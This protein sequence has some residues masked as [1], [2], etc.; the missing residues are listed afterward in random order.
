MPSMPPERRGDLQTPYGDIHY[1]A[2]GHGP[3]LV[4]L[5][6]GGRDAGMYDPVR[7]VLSAS[8]TV[9][10][11]DP[12][13][14]GLSFRPGRPMTIAERAAPL[15]DAA[16]Q[17]TD[18]RYSLYGMNGGNKLASAIAAEHSDALDGFI[19]AGLTHSIVIS[20]AGRAQTL[21][22]HPDVQRLLSS[23]E[24]DEHDRQDFYRAVTEFDLQDALARVSAPLAVLEFTTEEEDARI[25][26]QGASVAS[27]LGAVAHTHI[28][29]AADEQRSL[30]DRPEDLAAAIVSLLAALR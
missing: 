14:A 21:T 25:G 20:N 8:L 24:S 30:E 26:R 3:T 28:A 11:L 19:F 1:R 16:S 27:A 2:S 5:P 4:L 18:G 17:L 10:A 15:H 23:G 29:L 9:I 12:P 13:G 7:R 22:A 6:H